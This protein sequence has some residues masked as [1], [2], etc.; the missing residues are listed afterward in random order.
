MPLFFLLSG[1]SLS[2][3]Y[4]KE[5]WTIKFPWQR[6]DEG[7]RRFDYS[8]YFQNRFARIGPLYYLTQIF[9][10][11][12]YILLGHDSHFYSPGTLGMTIM[13]TLTCTNTWF[14][15]LSRRP[16]METAWTINTLFFFY[17][18]F[19]ILLS[20]LQK[21]NYNTMAR[22]IVLLHLMQLL[23][24]LPMIWI[25]ESYWIIT[26]NPLLRLPVFTM[27]M[28]AGLQNLRHEQSATCYDPN[29]DQPF[30]HDILP[31]GFFWT[32]RQ[33]NTKPSNKSQVKRKH[34]KDT[35]QRFKIVCFQN[36]I[37]YIWK[38]RVDINASIILLLIIVATILKI[39]HNNSVTFLNNYGQLYLV[40][41]QLII[42][43]GLTRDGGK[44]LVGRICRTTLFQVYVFKYNFRKTAKCMFYFGHLGVIQNYFQFLGK[45]SMPLYLLHN[46]IPVRFNLKLNRLQ[47]NFPCF[48]E[49]FTA[50]NS[51]Y[52]GGLLEDD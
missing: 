42:I 32:K 50:G 10:I 45:I 7:E 15:P 36:E 6:P 27:G 39:V 1:F 33:L 26:S 47:N 30:I 3:A 20:R 24:I 4:G 9:F 35:I 8:N 14:Y 40:H 19:P 49:I 22:C 51:W 46:D 17:L 29:L 18:M 48:S 2:M 11:P 28:L 34:E 5:D 37:E 16:F 23:C 13:A 44:S 25:P 41:M 43:V 38:R 52:C 21:L 12:P 31:W